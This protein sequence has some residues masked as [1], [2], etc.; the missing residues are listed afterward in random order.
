MNQ[1][2]PSIDNELRDIMNRLQGSTELVNE[3]RKF[4]GNRTVNRIVDFLYFNGNEFNFEERPI[5][6]WDIYFYVLGRY[7]FCYDNRKRF[8]K[9]LSEGK[10][11]PLPRRF[12][13]FLRY[14]YE[15]SLIAP[16][17]E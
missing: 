9:G 6:W 17:P 4:Y 1:N 16:K 14:A 5:N 7:C 11:P 8:L 3:V 13:I 2:K 15:G 10:R 12:K